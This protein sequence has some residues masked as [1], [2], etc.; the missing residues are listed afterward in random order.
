MNLKSEPILS[1][2]HHRVQNT[3]L[4]WVNSR[5]SLALIIYHLSSAVLVDWVW[6]PVVRCR[7]ENSPGWGLR[8]NWVLNHSFNLTYFIGHLLVLF[9]KLVDREL[10]I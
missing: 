6:V 2:E 10:S 8:W 9:I 3:N 1:P 4:L 7:Q 5:N